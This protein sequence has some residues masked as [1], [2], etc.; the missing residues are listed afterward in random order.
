MNDSIIDLTDSPPPPR[1]AAD[2][3]ASVIFMGATSGKRENP[4]RMPWVPNS[5]ARYARP[6][7]TGIPAGMPPKGM[8]PK[9]PVRPKQKSPEPVIEC[10]VCLRTCAQIRKANGKLM[11]TPCGHL[12]CENCLGESLRHNNRCPK[13]RQPAMKNTCIEIFL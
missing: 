5:H 2:L 11:T 3:D 10:P 1:R 13:C 7:A 4:F 12:F 6:D 9:P 8:P